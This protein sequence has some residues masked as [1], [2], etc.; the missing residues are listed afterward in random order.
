MAN[1]EIKAMIRQR[2]LYQYEVANELGVSE[3]T[4]CVWLRNELNPERKQKVLEA[5]ERLTGG[6]D[7]E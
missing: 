3:Y 2:R 6:G 4:L 5:M 1:A 7:S